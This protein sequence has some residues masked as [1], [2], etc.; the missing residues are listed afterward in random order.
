MNRIKI[1]YLFFIALTLGA[2][3]NNTPQNIDE[4]SAE[5]ALDYEG[6]YKGTYPC[7]DCPGIDATLILNK[8]KTFS[9]TNTYLDRDNEVLNYTGEYKIKGNVLSISLDGKPAHFFVGESSII[10]TGDKK[11]TSYTE[12]TDDYALRKMPSTEFTYSGLYKG[13]Y[14]CADCPG[15]ETSLLLRKDTTFLYTMTYLEEK[16][17]RFV[18]KGHYQVNGD[19]LTIKADDD[20]SVYFLIG[21]NQL[22]LMGK[23]LTLT[24]GETAPFYNLK[25]MPENFVYE[26]VYETFSETKGAYMQRLTI[27]QEQNNE[28]KV[29]FTASKVKNRENCRFSGKGTLKNDTLFVNIGTKGKVVTMSITPKHD[30]LGVDVFTPNFEERFQ[31]MVFCKGGGSLAGEYLKKT[32]TS[33]SIGVIKKG[34]TINDVFQNIPM[35]QIQKKKG[36]GE[37]AE[38]IYD[39]YEVSTRNGEPLFTLTPRFA[40]SIDQKINR[41]LV[42][43]PFFK[44]DKGICVNS[45][46]GAIKKAYTISGFAPTREHIVFNVDEINARFS[47]SKYKLKKGWWNE[48][49]KKVN[50]DKIPLNTQINDFTLWWEEKVVVK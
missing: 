43:S 48:Q 11:V 4:H 47:I 24:E 37:F 28:Y 36:E 7:A 41:V 13:T 32:I 30:G 9:Y 12:L 35:V 29:D 22:S 42:L 49:T 46:Y 21:A 15:I 17:G 19:T 16:D 5:Y 18:Y 34:M 39:D 45:T 2:C 40:G 3:Q 38:D 14:P 31:M 20:E 27:S 33:N 25:K 44:T 50:E 1:L 23:K 8:D 10:F 6:V 26:G